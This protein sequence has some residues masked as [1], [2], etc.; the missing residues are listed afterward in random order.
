MIRI[1]AA[2]PTGDEQGGL[3]LSRG[4]Y[5]EIGYLRG[6]VYVVVANGGTID[7][8]ALLAIA[9]SIP[10]VAAFDDLYGSYELPLDLASAT[11]DDLA[12]LL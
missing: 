10:L 2:V 7:T 11:D 8:P 3:W 12:S 1:D 5:N 9:G 4:E 6:L